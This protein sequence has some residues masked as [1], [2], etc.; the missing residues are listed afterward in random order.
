[1]SGTSLMSVTIRSVEWE[2]SGN[3]SRKI[4]V[5]ED[6]GEIRSI[7]CGHLA[8]AGYRVQSSRDGDEA[9]SVIASEPSFDVLVTDLTMPGVLNGKSLADAARRLQ[10]ELH[11]IFV[12]GYPPAA[13]VHCF[14]LKP[15]DDRVMK[16]VEGK[17][18]L[19]L[20]HDALT[21]RTI[22]G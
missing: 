17:T 8:R 13:L 10:P 19:R 5:V 2:A 4:L 22:G 14:G 1:M 12:S 16:P 7:I 3:G 20:V 15:S 6:D 9:L 11:V 21:P 18:L